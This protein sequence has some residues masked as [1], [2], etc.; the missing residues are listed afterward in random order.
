M[1]T[2]IINFGGFYH[3]IHSDLIEDAVENIICTDYEDNFDQ[4]MYDNF[5]WQEAHEKYCIEYLSKFEDWLTDELE[6]KETP[7]IEFK[8]LI[9]PRFYNY[10]TDKIEALISKK[11][12][13]E[14]QS[15]LLA[16]EEFKE[17]FKEYLKERTTSD[18]GYIS[19]YTY[20]EALNNKEE[21][22][23]DY[24]L[25]FFADIYNSEGLF[26]SI[27]EVNVYEAIM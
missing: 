27:H 16:S 25:E 7:Q 8:E 21:K 5:N 22:L 18:P 1:K 12:I 11:N 24:I 3:S 23:I 4:K 13:Q 20:E 19:F 2:T 10:T 6:L 14:I 9:S 26:N 17:P 15:K